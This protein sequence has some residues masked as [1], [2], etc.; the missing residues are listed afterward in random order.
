M[1][2]MARTP[3]T[4][5]YI[6]A[7]ISPRSEATRSDNDT[8][9][10]AAP[11]GNVPIVDSSYWEDGDVHAW[12]TVPLDDDA[13]PS[14]CCR[15]VLSRPASGRPGDQSRV[16]RCSCGLQIC[17]SHDRR[18]SIIAYAAHVSREASPFAIATTAR[19]LE[20]AIGALDLA[21]DHARICDPVQAALVREIRD[22]ISF[23][24]DPRGPCDKVE[25]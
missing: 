11:I 18:A 12:T 14:D 22:L 6:A 2:E 10:D 4:P 19:A 9:V 17:P 20:I 1:I 7:R 23:P 21:I 16:E 3:V 15:P 13:I 25:L 24:R 8:L 5:R